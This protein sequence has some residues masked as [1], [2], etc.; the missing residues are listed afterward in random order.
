VNGTADLGEEGKS[1]GN[2]TEEDGKRNEKLLSSKSKKRLSWNVGQWGF[3]S[4]QRTWGKK[5]KSGNVRPE[6]E[7][8]VSRGGTEPAGVKTGTP[9]LV[10]WECPSCLAAS[11][12]GGKGGGLD[13][14]LFSMRVG[15]CVRGAEFRPVCIPLLFLTAMASRGG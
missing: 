1:R 2:T 5:R 7:E 3:P 11:P 13:V 8:K 9:G 12:S 10:Q 15:K 4:P 14:F 6:G